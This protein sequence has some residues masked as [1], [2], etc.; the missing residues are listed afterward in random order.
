MSNVNGVVEAATA[1]LVLEEPGNIDA[2]VVLGYM[3]GRPIPDTTLRIG[4]GANIRSGSIVY[5]GATFKQGIMLSSARKQPLATMWAS[6]AIRLLTMAAA[7]V[8]TS[9]STPMSMWRSSRRLRMTL[10]LRRV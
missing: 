3:T 2:N 9:K 8:T 6:G 1:P 10:F 4:A 7:L 5:A